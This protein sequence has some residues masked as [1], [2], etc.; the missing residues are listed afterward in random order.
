M[1]IGN[2]AAGALGERADAP[3]RV[4]RSHEQRGIGRIAAILGE[5]DSPNERGIGGR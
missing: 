3:V 2:S 1:C 5:E 4:P